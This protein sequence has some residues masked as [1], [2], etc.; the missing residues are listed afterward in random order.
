MALTEFETRR[1]EKVMS[2]FIE[3]CRPPMHLRKEVDLAF[4]LDRQTVDIFEIRILPWDPV[5]LEQPIARAR[6]V[7][8][9]NCWNVYWMRADLKW[10]AY[11]PEPTVR[12]IEAFCALVNEDAYACF[13]G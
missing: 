4:R 10:H 9:R 8:S 5:P 13:W 2:E 12:N 7:K 11:E 6:W 1:V 3:I